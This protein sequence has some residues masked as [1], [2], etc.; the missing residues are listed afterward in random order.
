MELF[1]HQKV[2]GIITITSGL[3]ALACMIASAI[4]VNYNFDAFYNPVL[5]LTTPGANA[6]AARWS[7]IFDMLGYYLLLLPVIYLLHDWIKTRTPWSR[8]ITVSGMAYILVGAIGASILAVVWPHIINTYPLA[9]ASQQE[10]LKSNFELVNAMV[11]GGMWNLLEMFFAATWWIATG[12]LLYKHNHKLVGSTAL[13]TGIFSLADG[14]AGMFELSKLHELALNAYLLL[15][16]AWAI[17]TGI[18]L[19][20]SPLAKS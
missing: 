14:L 16:I 15:A 7:M 19:L 8:V 20:R 6:Q 4:G 18:F 1:R 12:I 13:L 2:I 17:L 9:P 10:I 5:I 11:Y 3:L